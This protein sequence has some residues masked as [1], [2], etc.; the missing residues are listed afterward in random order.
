VFL[1]WQVIIMTSNLGADILS[2]L[3][4]DQPSS[5]G[6]DAVMHLI[7]Q[8]FAPEWLN[9]L[10]DIVLFNR[11]NRVDMDRI[12]LRQ[13]DLVR[14][15]LGENRINLDATEDVIRWLADEGFDPVFG[16]RPLKRVLQS[17]VLNPL[18]NIIL[19]GKCKPEDTVTLL[20]VKKEDIREDDVV[21]SEEKGEVSSMLMGDQEVVLRIVPKTTSEL[22]PTY[23]IATRQDDGPIA[24]S[25]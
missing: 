23:P 11:L 14:E 19:E 17:R 5:A 22:A 8:T 10:D 3:P 25:A 21:L 1:I 6:K 12:V 4:P 16:A 2:N 15:M 13:L 20:Q 9:R 18:A 24:A 7:R